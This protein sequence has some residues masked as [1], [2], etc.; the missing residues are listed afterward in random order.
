MT[1]ES[2]D[3]EDGYDY[4]EVRI[5]SNWLQRYSGSSLPGPFTGTDISLT[6][7]TDDSGT[8]LGFFATVVQLNT[9]RGNETG[10]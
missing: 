1:F 3:L 2:F 10:E 4:I 9:N 5:G 8:G 7:I 6:F